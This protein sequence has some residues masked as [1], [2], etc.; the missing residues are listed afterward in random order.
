VEQWQNVIPQIF[1]YVVALAFS[2]TRSLAIFAVF[3]VIARLGLPRLLQ[4]PIV[5]AISVP[6]V[7][8]V[9][10]QLRGLDNLSPLFI[11]YV[12]VKEVLIGLLLGIIAG[13]PFWI[14]EM[15]GNI[16][17]FVRQAPDAEVQDPQGATQASISGNLFAIV[18]T[19]Y[20]ILA[21]GLSILASTIY[22]SYE[23]W[24]ALS[25]LPF[26]DSSGAGKVI[27]LVDFLIR[28]ALL[29]AAPLVTFILMG[30][31]LVIMIAKILP[32]MNVFTLSMA[33]RNF[34]FLIAV[35]I[36]GI[37]LISSYT[38]NITYIKDTIRIARDFLNG[39]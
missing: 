4:I 2:I 38:S 1:L 27:G 12:C 36:F 28:S 22:Q 7:I 9:H 15:A 33:F 17:D 39:E 23:V 32:Q 14:M 6:I 26:P 16:V 29:I 34:A 35:Q 24:P 3:P 13:I 8:Q 30:F 18:I 31:L 5:I 11:I 19:L 10:G 25:N 21:G 37:Y 20:F